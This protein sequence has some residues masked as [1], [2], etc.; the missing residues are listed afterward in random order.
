M[1]A[2]SSACSAAPRQRE[3]TLAGCVLARLLQ[4]R[5]AAELRMKRTPTLEFVYDDSVDRGMR[6]SE[7]LEDEGEPSE[8]AATELEPV[9]AELRRPTSCC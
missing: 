8:P 1:P 5:I 6:I 9:L 3:Q 4:A 7:L 2:C